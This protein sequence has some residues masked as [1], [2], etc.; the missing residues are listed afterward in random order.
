MLKNKSEIR[1]KN[2]NGQQ[3]NEK[4]ERGQINTQKVLINLRHTVCPKKVVPL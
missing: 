2:K 1:L 4:N 3:K